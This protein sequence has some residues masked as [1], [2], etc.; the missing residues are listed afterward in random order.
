MNKPSSPW[1]IKGVSPVARDAAK[2][3]ARISQQ[4]L[5]RWLNQV[6]RVTSEAEGASPATA[7][8]PSSHADTKSIPSP[9]SAVTWQEAVAR[10]EARI[11][12][13][14]R[15]AADLVVPVNDSLERIADRLEAIETYVLRR[16]RQS[17]L[18]RLLRR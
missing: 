13:S 11:F 8:G 5:G 9:S 10:L 14:E 16:P 2:E 17:Y 4:P 12:Q 3:G 1:S 15:N 7:D 6:I 18:S